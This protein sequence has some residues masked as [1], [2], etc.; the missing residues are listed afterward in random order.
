M[1]NQGLFRVATMCRMLDVSPGGYYAWRLRSRCARGRQDA[2]LLERSRRLHEHSRGTYG[3]PRLHVDLAT[4]GVQVGRKRVARLM[5][6]AGLKGVSW[7]KG[8]KTTAS[9]QNAR[10][11]PDLVERAFTAAGPDQLGVADIAYIATSSGFLFL[12]VVV[13]VWSRKVVGL[14]METHLRPELALAALEM[15]VLERQPQAAIHHPDQGCQYMSTAFGKRCGEAGVRPSMGSVGNSLDNPM[16]ES[17]FAT[18]ECE[19]LDRRRFRSQTEARLAVFDFVEV[20]Y[21]QER[22]HSALAHVSPFEYERRHQA[23]G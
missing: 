4:A 13:D 16:C 20:W 9:A 18:L 22:R 5:R 17:F 7:R 8:W 23:T 12:A 15:A 21:N 19:L 2:E 10:P 6:A 11:G 1:A 14:A 3:S